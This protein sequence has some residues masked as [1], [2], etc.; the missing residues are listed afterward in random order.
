MIQITQKKMF[1]AVLNENENAVY[2]L[3]NQF[4]ENFQFELFKVL[5]ESPSQLTEKASSTIDQMEEIVETYKKVPVFPLTNSNNL[6]EDFRQKEGQII[7]WIEKHL[8]KNGLSNYEKRKIRTLFFQIILYLPKEKQLEFLQHTFIKQFSAT[9]NKLDEE[10][11]S[12]Q[13]EQLST[14]T[15]IYSSKEA[16]FTSGD[17]LPKPETNFN[18]S[19][20]V[21]FAGLTLLH[22][23][24]PNYFKYLNLVEKGKFI[25]RE[26]QERCLHLLHFLATGTFEPFEHLLGVPKL[27]CYWPRDMPVAKEIELTELE[28]KESEDLL[29]AVINHW[30]V[31]KS[32]SIGGLREAFLKRGGLLSFNSHQNHWQLQ[33]ERKGQDI[34]LDKLS[35]GYGVI[36]LPWMQEQL[37]VEW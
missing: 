34:L 10:T 6:V 7:D 22:P 5:Q 21:S 16:S 1:G 20:K 29:N 11:I 18:L 14:K 27:L 17:D 26:A 15:P 24:L 8:K 35:W 2:R 25:S 32:T 9:S 28:L 19:K 36:K 23:F 13:F 31:L 4:S 30:A 3:M 12:L 37:I 33:I